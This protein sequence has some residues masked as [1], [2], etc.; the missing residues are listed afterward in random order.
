MTEQ[1]TPTGGIPRQRTAG[2]PLADAGAPMAGWVTFAGVV[3]AVVGCFA[4]FEGFVALF[5]PTSFVA[6]AAGVLVLD[7]SGWGWLHI[8]LGALVLLTGLSLVGS[9]PSWARAVGIVLVAINMI[10][11]LAFLP[12]YPIWSI[13]VIVLDMIILYALMV[14]WVPSDAR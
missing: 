6:T 14:S 9:A 13:V 7:L 10:V 5:A 1:Q 4:I 12:S 11:Q 3:M 2:P 8:I